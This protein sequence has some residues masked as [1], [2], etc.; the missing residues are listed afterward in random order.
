MRTT[1]GEACKHALSRR[2]TKESAEW[3]MI[4]VQ[5]VQAAGRPSEFLG[6][7][8]MD[9]RWR[10]D[11]HNGRSTVFRVESGEHTVSV[12]IKRRYRVEGYR[13]RA[14]ASLAVVVQP[15]EH[16][17]LVFG[18]ANVRMQ[19]TTTTSPWF[20]FVCVA[21]VSLAAGIGWLAF[22]VLRDAVDWTTRALGAREPWLS[23]FRS[24]VSTRRMC[25][26][27]TMVAWAI[28]AHFSLEKRVRTLSY[29]PVSP[30]FLSRKPDFGKPIPVLKQPYVDPFE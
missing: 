25:A 12:H 22:P 5:P 2:G 23:W 17:E 29:K 8:I 11:M 18:V 20:I 27:F 7:A 9:G 1:L 30:Y 3:S 6:V 4:S 14:T 26:A 28:A 19:P 24:V 13:G 15:G 10:S 21:S 16:L